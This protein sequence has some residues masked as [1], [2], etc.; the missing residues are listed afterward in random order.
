MLSIV[1]CKVVARPN[2][3][4]SPEGSLKLLVVLAIVMLVVSVGFI[5]IGAWLVMPFAGM[6]LLAFAIAFHYV[7]LHSAD[8]ESI[9]IEADRV[10]VEKRDYR[11]E[12]STV[13]QRYWTQ[14]SLRESFGGRSALYIGSHGKEVEF[15]KHLIDDEQRIVVMRELKQK[16]KNIS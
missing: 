9:T 7:N 16:L 1:D 2:A 5:H 14:V 4:L 13:F 15:G 8:F 3:S 11:N 6:E 10:V 12:S